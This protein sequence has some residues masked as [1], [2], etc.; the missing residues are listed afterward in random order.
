MSANY[1]FLA[2]VSISIKYTNS[3]TC[4]HS[5]DPKRILEFIQYYIYMHV[6]IQNRSIRPRFFSWTVFVYCSSLQWDSNSHRWYTVNL[7]LLYILT[8]FAYRR[9]IYNVAHCHLYYAIVQFLSLPYY[10]V[11]NF[12]FY[13]Y[14]FQWFIQY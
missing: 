7:I 4:I 6:K 1:L 8:I 12:G 3:L 13:S 11:I 5:Q 9:T 14:R 2:F 10:N